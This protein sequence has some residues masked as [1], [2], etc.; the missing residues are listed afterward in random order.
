MVYPNHILDTGASQST[1]GISA[2]E[3][4]ANA[5][6]EKLLLDATAPKHSRVLLYIV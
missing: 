4:L 3:K 5:L 1:G 2:A 6:G